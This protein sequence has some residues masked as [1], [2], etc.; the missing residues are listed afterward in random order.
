V[1]Q[2]QQVAGGD[3]SARGVEAAGQRPG[4][5]ASACGGGGGAG[6]VEDRVARPRPARGLW[7]VRDL[8]RDGER[9]ICA[10]ETSAV[11]V[12][13]SLSPMTNFNTGLHTADPEVARGDIAHIRQ[14]FLG[15]EAL[16]GA[17]S[18][19]IRTRPA[20]SVT[21]HCR[22][23]RRQ[24]ALASGRSVSRESGR[25]ARPGLSSGLI[26]AG[27]LVS[28]AVHGGRVHSCAPLAEP[29]RTDVCR[30]GKRV[31]ATPW[32]RRLHPAPPGRG[33]TWPHLVTVDRQTS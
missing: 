2:T 17:P 24:G 20:G 9:F 6:V 7:V 19:P 22:G 14:A 5:V 3:S 13:P 15:S 21:R 27:A 33:L 25:V 1:G 28:G 4:C 18:H 26:R 10:S 30:L 31:G 32:L 16:L 11:V 23:L 12:L 29:T 8:M